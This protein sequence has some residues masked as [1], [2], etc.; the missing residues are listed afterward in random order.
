MHSIFYAFSLN[1]SVFGLK[2]GLGGQ[3]GEK[4]KVSGL[5]LKNKQKL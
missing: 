5:L 2:Y 1:N 3:K 4:K